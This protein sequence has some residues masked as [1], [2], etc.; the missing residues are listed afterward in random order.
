LTGNSG[1]AA[2]AMQHAHSHAAA[3]TYPAGQVL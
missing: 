2:C 1:K 3:R